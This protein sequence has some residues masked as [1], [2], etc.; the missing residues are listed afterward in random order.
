MSAPAR[1]SL[2]RDADSFFFL[3]MN[4]R[5]QVEHPV[6]E[7]ITGIDLVEWQLRVAAGEKLPVDRNPSGR[8]RH[9]RPCDRGTHLC[10]GRGERFSARNRNYPP[11]ARACGQRHSRRYRVSRR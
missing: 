3:E 7:M 11:L 2:L 9:R 8:G 10:R 1:S 5:L 6:T 4:T